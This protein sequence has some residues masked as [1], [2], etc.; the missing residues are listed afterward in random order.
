MSEGLRGSESK[1]RS[2]G[3]IVP[4]QTAGNSRLAKAVKAGI[5][6][7]TQ[8]MSLAQQYHLPP[9]TKLFSTGLTQPGM[10]AR[11]IS[12]VCRDLQRAREVFTERAWFVVGI[13]CQW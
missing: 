12:I 11:R 1:E 2:I 9:G 7:T 4:G 13:V 6:A 3:R 10:L 8:R 5:E